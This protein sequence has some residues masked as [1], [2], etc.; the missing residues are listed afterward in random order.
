MTK[1]EANLEI[2]RTNLW[3][4]QWLR[5]RASTAGVMVYTPGQRSSTRLK[6]Q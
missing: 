5:L 4:V 1:K 3:T 2:Q 6:V